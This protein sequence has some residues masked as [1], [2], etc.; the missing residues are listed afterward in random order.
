M[1]MQTFSPSL[2]NSDSFAPWAFRLSAAPAISGSVNWGQGRGWASGNSLDGAGGGEKW[3]PEE[4]SSAIPAPSGF[5]LSYQVAAR[6][7][8][9]FG[10]HLGRKN[11]CLLERSG[12][13]P[14]SRAAGLKGRD[15]ALRALHD[16][17]GPPPTPACA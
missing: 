14:W 12:R 9:S 4:G 2:I 13:V 7:P 8:L 6:R 1:K 3:A 11:T 5:H 10:L 17:D 16:V 15:L